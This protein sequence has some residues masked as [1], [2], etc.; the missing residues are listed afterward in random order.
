[1]ATGL[2]RGTKK[3]ENHW[4]VGLIS[5]VRIDENNVR[6]ER[7]ASESKTEVKYIYLRQYNVALS[8]IAAIVCWKIAEQDRAA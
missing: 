2:G 7:S 6:A 8:L 1:M 4:C 3:V 5:S